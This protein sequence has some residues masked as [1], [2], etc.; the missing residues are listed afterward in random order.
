MNKFIKFTAYILVLS[1]MLG[2]PIS[3]HAGCKEPK[4]GPP[5]SQGP[6]GPQGIQGPIGPVGPPF[7]VS[8]GT[9]NLPGINQIDVADGDI[10]PYSVTETSSGITN[11]A[12]DITLTKSGVYQVTFG[13]IIDPD[14]GGADHFNIELNGTVVSGGSI[15]PGPGFVFNTITVMFTA[16]A[17]D[18]LVVRNVSGHTTRIGI[19]GADQ[20]AS[21][22]SILQIK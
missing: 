13:V 2:A 14:T 20:V 17:G 8:Y 6:Q 12:G 5:G 21:Y 3:A 11:A 22:I 18:H 7:V 15:F 1:L 9:F 4:Q 19:L 10:I 16:V